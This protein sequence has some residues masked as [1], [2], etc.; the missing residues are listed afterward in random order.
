VPP[1][2]FVAG[3]STVLT[4]GPKYLETTPFFKTFT[5]LQDESFPIILVI[6][7][8]VLALPYV[9][10]S[11][12]A[13]LGAIDVRT[14]V[15]AARNLGAG[16]PQVILQVIVPNLRSALASASFLTLALVLGE[17]TIA[18]LLGFRPFAV[19]IVS[20][21]GRNPQ[22]S[23]AV[24]IFSLALTWILLLVL[25]TSGTRGTAMKETDA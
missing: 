15:E 6:A 20:I 22:L 8:V 23:V 13:G 21:S 10:R 18:N 12:D 16:W 7:Y 25:S 19:W 14:L 2:T 1:I 9:Y 17:F 11:L 3:I 5:A 24:S 4:W